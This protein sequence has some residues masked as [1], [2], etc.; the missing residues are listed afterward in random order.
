MRSAVWWIVSAVGVAAFVAWLWLKDWLE[1]AD[2]ASSVVSGFAGVAALTLAVVSMAA[3]RRSGGQEPLAQLDLAVDE[4]ARLVD[5]Q[6]EREAS[7]RGLLHP[8]PLRVAWRSTSRP[9]SPRAAEI[10]DATPGVTPTRLR[11]TDDV[12]NVAATW[13]RLPS[14]QLVVIG[15]PGSG[16][17]SLA[18]L[19]VRQIVATR[20]PGDPVPV[21]LNLMGWDPQRVHFDTW[22]ARRLA[23]DY[24]RL[25]AKR[26]Y[27]RDAA[28]R[29]VDRRLVIPVLDGL[30]EMPES[31]RPQAIAALTEAIG[32]AR[33]LVL[34]CRAEEYEAAVASVGAPLARAAVVELEPVSFTEIA[35]YLT[36]GL[37]NGDQRWAGVTERL[38]DEPD[39]VLAT[40]LSTPLMAYLARIAYRDP[41]AD[42]GVLLE[43]GDV[44][45]ELLAAYLPTVY[46]S[47]PGEQSE[48]RPEL[49]EQWLGGL[50]RQMTKRGDGSLRLW[51]LRSV[52]GVPAAWGVGT[53]VLLAALT[54][55]L[56]LFTKGRLLGQTGAFVVVLVVFVTSLVFTGWSHELRQV[57]RVVPYRV[58]L[59]AIG[60]KVGILAGQIGF[61]WTIISAQLFMDSSGL[62]GPNFLLGLSVFLVAGIAC[63]AGALAGALVNASPRNQAFEPSVALKQDLVAWCVVCFISILAVLAMLLVKGEFSWLALIGYGVCLGSAIAT[64]LGVGATA[65]RWFAVHVTLMLAGVLPL[66]ATRFIEDAHRR[67]VLRVVGMEYQFRHAKIQTYLAAL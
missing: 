60:V 61:M 27:G 39:G 66:R 16:K 22:L 9:V 38:R 15:A 1:T 65:S 17:S 54:S 52:V 6:C 25:I 49:A 50:A 37:V 3:A 51:S 4:L 12:S 55:L 36:A 43:T 58:E 32:G 7:I 35:G 67:G 18:M 11:L 30:D 56:L 53:V 28:R 45:R 42:P 62:K 24:P 26:Y 44:E 63:A 20:A 46:R 23:V 64:A 21:L 2:R 31:A 41:G 5:S 13:A 10:L 14:R 19:L 57:P 47:V 59:N 8:E 29:L 48:H 34:T 33:P 40:A